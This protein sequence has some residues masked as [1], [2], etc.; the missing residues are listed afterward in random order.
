MPLQAHGD[1]NHICI[2]YGE[3]GVPADRHVNSSTG[4]D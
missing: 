3:E 1:H 4:T 2:D